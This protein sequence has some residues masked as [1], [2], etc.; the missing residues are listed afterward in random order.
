MSIFPKCTHPRINLQVTTALGLASL[1]GLLGKVE[2]ME[3]I[4]G[5][6]MLKFS[7]AKEVTCLANSRRCN[8]PEMLQTIIT[9]IT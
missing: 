1:S 4:F 8:P 2:F 5:A 3:Q 7:R 6:F 9:V